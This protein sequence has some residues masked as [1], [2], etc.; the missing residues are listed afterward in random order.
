MEEQCSGYLYDG[1][2]L[3]NCPYGTFAISLTACGDCGQFCEE[4]DAADN[5]LE[6]QD[7]F[8][9]YDSGNGKLSCVS[10]CPLVT[11]ANNDYCL[12]CP[13]PC[14]TCYSDEEYIYC[15][16]C[17][18]TYFLLDELCLSACPAGYK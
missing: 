6:C 18:S 11:Y 2:C 8:F 17:I 3:N 16:T 10:E 9:A 13:S 7:G 14:L 12:V 15:L 1:E 5:C 4:C